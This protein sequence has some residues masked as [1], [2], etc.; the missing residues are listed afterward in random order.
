MGLNT[1]GGDNYV[2]H[3]KVIRVK[4]G[5][6]GKRKKERRQRRGGQNNWKTN[7]DKNTESDTK[8]VWVLS[9]ILCLLFKNN[10]K[11]RFYCG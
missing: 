9:S 8:L 7:T 11:S 3:M 5:S 2:R 4:E 1:P 10:L 6:G